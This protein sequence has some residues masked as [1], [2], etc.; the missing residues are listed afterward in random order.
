MHPV[1]VSS[2]RSRLPRE[3]RCLRVDETQAQRRANGVDER[4][5]GHGRIG[6]GGK[7][8]EVETERVRR[9]IKRDPIEVE[10]RIQD[11]DLPRRSTRDRSG[12]VNGELSGSITP[13]PAYRG[14]RGASF[15]N[16]VISESER[17][18]I[19][20]RRVFILSDYLVAGKYCAHDV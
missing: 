1:R 7:A 14:K 11:F 2:H 12:G 4:V 6:Q 8:L 16:R 18:S 13:G 20:G 19:T 17:A 3:P 15:I 10:S 5:V 9:I